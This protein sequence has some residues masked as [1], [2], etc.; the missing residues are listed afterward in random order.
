[1]RAALGVQ[2]SAL[3]TEAG[4]LP[5]LSLE[6]IAFLHSHFS[7]SSALGNLPDASALERIRTAP[8][9][10]QRA[11][12]HALSGAS[13]PRLGGKAHPQCPN[14]QE[15]SRRSIS[16]RAHLLVVVFPDWAALLPPWPNDCA[17]KV[18]S[19]S[20]SA[21]IDAREYEVVEKIP[22]YLYEIV[23]ADCCVTFLFPSTPRY[24][25]IS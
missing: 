10:C 3:N 5:A 16:D 8:K 24:P 4:C 2:T 1:M 20:M 25:M 14:P 19:S 17:T 9:S 11:S 22:V 18:P 15:R 21:P 23:F 12:Q 13:G 6:T 7:P